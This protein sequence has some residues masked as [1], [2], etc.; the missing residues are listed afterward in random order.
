MLILIRLTYY[1]SYESAH[2]AN[3]TNRQIHAHFSILIFVNFFRLLLMTTIGRYI[4]R[5][6]YSNVLTTNDPQT[7][8]LRKKITFI[9]ITRNK[10]ILFGN[11]QRGFYQQRL[12]AF[13]VHAYGEHKM[14]FVGFSIILWPI[15]CCLIL[16]AFALRMTLLLFLLFIIH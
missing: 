7:K 9:N 15:H 2:T 8:K 11:D 1:I 14:V 13:L 12:R 4:Y 10:W 5:G 16:S 6:Q 3:M